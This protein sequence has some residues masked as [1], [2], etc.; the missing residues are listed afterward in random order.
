MI[1]T[2][3]GISA[4]M[5]AEDVFVWESYV[6]TTGL[7]NGLVINVSAAQNLDVTLGKA[8]HCIVSKLSELRPR[9]GEWMGEI[10]GRLRNRYE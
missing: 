2:G 7:E 1:I 8:D 4:E 10:M 3:A 6:K 5:S 9:T